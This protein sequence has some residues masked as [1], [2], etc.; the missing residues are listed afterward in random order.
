MG[1]TASK[2]PGNAG[3]VTVSK[4]ERQA[5]IDPD[6]AALQ[7]LPSVTPLIPPSTMGSLGSLFSGRQASMSMPALHT[8]NVS[9]LC[10]EYTA[11]S[12]R[13]ALPICEEQRAIMRKMTSVETIC[14]RSLY[15]MALRSSELAA[16]ASTLRQHRDLC[17]RVRAAK[18]TVHETRMRC[19]ALEARASRIEARSGVLSDA[20]LR[21]EVV[22]G[23][24]E[25]G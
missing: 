2:L 21:R 23:E 15:L 3:I 4:R 13:E 14:T 5:K 12:R 18:A 10:R 17:D 9:A 20:V 1:G 16:S 7:R 8:R 19:D 22:S 11:L 6:L 24:R 25:L